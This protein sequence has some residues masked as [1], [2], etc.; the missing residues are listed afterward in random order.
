MKKL[1]FLSSLLLFLILV[2]GH[3]SKCDTFLEMWSM[4][5]TVFTAIPF[6]LVA[7]NPPPYK[8]LVNRTVII[9]SNNCV[10]T[11][12]ATVPLGLTTID[13]GTNCAGGNVTAV[14]LGYSFG[15]AGNLLG[16]Y[17]VDQPS[18]SY[19][20]LCSE[21]NDGPS[22]YWYIPNNGTCM[23]V[24]NLAGGTFSQPDIDLHRTLCLS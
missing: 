8:L 9:Y 4:S 17:Y 11:I 21:V 10:P 5:S 2:D 18:F 13:F 14:F 3:G 16:L 12:F 1:I 6:S 23:P 22:M 15:A 7:S 19:F 20:I 24:G